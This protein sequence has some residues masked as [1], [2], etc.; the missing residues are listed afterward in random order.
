MGCCGESI[1]R[2]PKTSLVIGVDEARGEQL[3]PQIQSDAGLRVLDYLHKLR[4]VSPPDILEMDWD[5]RTTSFLSGQT[6]LAY[7]WTVRAARFETDVSSAVK[8]KVRYLPQPRGPAG[9]SN[10]P[11][12]G[13]LLCIPSNLS[14]ER[15]ELAF[16][17]IAWM[18]SPEAMK[19]NVQNGFPVAPRFSVSAD[20]EAAA[21]SPIV[22]VV[23]KLAKQSLLKAWPRPPVPEYLSLE[24]ILGEEIHRALRREVGDRQ[25]L[26]NAQVQADEVMRAAGYY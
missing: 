16:E 9:A 20:P 26:K 5:R 1:L 14:P 3:R 4:E 12:G 13:F 21:T 6:A 11:I 24:A 7:C 18:T 23:D 17:A 10:N 19:A 8:R 2:I 22:S 15:I 25:A